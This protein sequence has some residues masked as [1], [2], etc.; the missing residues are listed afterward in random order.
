MESVFERVTI[1]GVGLIALGIGL[2]ALSYWTAQPGGT[3]LAFIGLIGIGA[4][5]LFIEG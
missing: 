3:Y 5:M 2:T 1:V 4:Y